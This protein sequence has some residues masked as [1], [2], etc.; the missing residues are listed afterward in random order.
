VNRT[1]SVLFS[2]ESQARGTGRIASA[3]SGGS[4]GVELGVSQI[5]AGETTRPSASRFGRYFNAAGSRLDRTG[6]QLWSGQI[7][8]YLALFVRFFLGLTQV[9]DHLRPSLRAVVS[10]VDPQAIHS[11]QKKV[12]NQLIIGCGFGWH[13]HHDPHVA[14]VR[15]RAQK[16]LGIFFQKDSALTQPENAVRWRPARVLGTTE[17]LQHVHD[18]VRSAHDVRFRAPQ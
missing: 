16:G 18:G 12:A 3:G 4:S 15:R 6:T 7:H 9:S 13:G 17:T 11:A 14:S 2:R 10:A 8:H 5:R 1:Q